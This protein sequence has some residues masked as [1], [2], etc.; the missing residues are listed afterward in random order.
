MSAA[1]FIFIWLITSP[2]WVTTMLIRIGW[3]AV[4]FGWTVGENFIKWAIRRK[5]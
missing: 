3:S 4:Q 1:A 2:I 5:P